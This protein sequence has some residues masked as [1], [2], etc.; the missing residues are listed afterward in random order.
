M[1]YFFHAEGNERV[2]DE[3]GLMLPT[4]S[5]AVD[6][7]RAMATL[8]NAHDMREANWHIV[9]VNEGGEQVIRI[10]VAAKQIG[11]PN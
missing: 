10:P 5:A 11:K 1:R 3:A 8:L 2:E 4:D 9:V 6:E 7:A